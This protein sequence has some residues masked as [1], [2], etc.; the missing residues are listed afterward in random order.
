MYLTCHSG[1]ICMEA[2]TSLW[3]KGGG[4]GGEKEALRGKDGGEAAIGM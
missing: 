1:L 4:K 2:S 3:K